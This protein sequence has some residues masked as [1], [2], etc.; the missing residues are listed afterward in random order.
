MIRCQNCEKPLT[1]KQRQFCSDAC[2]KQSARREASAN[3]RELSA[4]VRELSANGRN[5]CN[6]RNFIVTVRVTFS[7][8]S[9]PAEWD[10]GLINAHIRRRLETKLLE[11]LSDEQ[12]DWKIEVKIDSKMV[13]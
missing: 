4:N 2:R 9:Q 10:C 5:Y 6:I 13:E 1:G 3:V 7:S 12:P 11:I 8:N